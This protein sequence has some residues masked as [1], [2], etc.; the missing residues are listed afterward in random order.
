[1]GCNQSKATLAVE[2]PDDSRPVAMEKQVGNV[3][4][5]HRVARASSMII[6]LEDSEEMKVA[7]PEQAPAPKTEAKPEEKSEEAK[8]ETN[9]DESSRPISQSVP[10]PRVVKSRQPNGDWENDGDQ[11]SIARVLAARNA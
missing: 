10:Q 8:A 1:M 7:V 9:Q 6:K 3:I 11:N 4:Q 5:A 2:L